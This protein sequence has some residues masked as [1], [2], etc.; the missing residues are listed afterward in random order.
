MLKKERLDLLDGC[1]DGCS[2]HCV[3][4]LKVSYQTKNPAHACLINTFLYKKIEKCQKIY[5]AD[6][7]NGRL[8]RYNTNRFS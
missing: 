3:L 2:I 8:K 7:A 6:I 5:S 1:D 4:S